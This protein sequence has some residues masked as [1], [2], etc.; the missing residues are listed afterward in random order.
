MTPVP[1]CDGLIDPLPALSA[2]PEFRLLYKVSVNPTS[3]YLNPSVLAWPKLLLITS[4][5]DWWDCKLDNPVQSDCDRPIF[6]AS[7]CAW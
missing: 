1:F 4:V 7:N 5:H 2:A 3:E 6:I